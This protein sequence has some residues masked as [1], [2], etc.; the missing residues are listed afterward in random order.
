M[1]R[2]TLF[3]LVFASCALT[4]D[5]RRDRG[6]PRELL[7]SG[8]YDRTFTV[9][10]LPLWVR[11][12]LLQSTSSQAYGMADPDQ[13]WA[14]GCIVD[15]NHPPHQ[16]IYAGHWRDYWFA[17]FRSGGIA[18]GEELYVFHN[19]DGDVAKAWSYMARPRG[20]SVALFISRLEQ[21][22]S[23]FVSPPRRA[24]MGD[25]IAHCLHGT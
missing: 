7:V 3:L 4:R 1:R 20:E 12:A 15:A 21:G 5:A 8:E 13:Q 14:N 9:K 18:Y 10:G 17:A 2:L 22:D 11:E 16:L 19:V 25:E 6:I 24:Y 23:C